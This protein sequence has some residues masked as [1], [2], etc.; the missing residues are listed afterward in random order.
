MNEKTLRE[1]LILARRFVEQA[2][3]VQSDY[4]RMDG[5]TPSPKKTGALRRT[6]LDLTRAL[7]EMRK[8]G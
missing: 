4:R 5:M 2:K 6:S 7:A 8:P 1:A 3:D